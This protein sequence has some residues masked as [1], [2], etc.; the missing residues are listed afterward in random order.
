MTTGLAQTQDALTQ[1][2]QGFGYATLV[3]FARE[4]ARSILLQKIAYYQ[5]RIDF[6]E[7]KYGLRFD[8]F[9]NGFSQ[10][11]TYSLLEK[12]DDSL[13]WETALDVVKSYQADLIALNR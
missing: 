2:I 9:I 1:T 8:Q 4:Q 3:D 13:S 6:F 10:I 11:R 7:Q 12:E 5:G